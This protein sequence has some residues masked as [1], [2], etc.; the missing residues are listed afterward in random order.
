MNIP[1][2]MTLLRLCLVSTS[3]LAG[4]GA[5]AADETPIPS[6][7]KVQEINYSYVGFTTAYDCR[8]AEDK[9]KA[10][11]KAVGAHPNTKVR[12]SGCDFNRPSRNFF[13]TITTATPAPIADV[14]QT[15]ADKSRQQLLQ[16]LGVASDF[17]T[18]E[19]PAV[20]TSVDLSKDR[21][22]NIQPGDC[23]LLAGL[24]DQ[25]F[26]K[27][28]IKVEEDRVTCTPNRLSILAP[29]LRVSALTALKDPDKS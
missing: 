11:L 2:R 7:W 18:D 17:S 8:S 20:W 13:V 26:P 21:R 29:Q 19:F 5:S 4:V 24:R 6:T 16:R 28:G 23:E 3:L 1:L 10:I 22:L 27:L 12:A 15:Q 14:K 25:V 9:V